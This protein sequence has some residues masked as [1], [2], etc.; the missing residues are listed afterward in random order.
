LRE[1]EVRPDITLGHSSG[2]LNAV[3]EAGGLSLAEGFRLIASRAALMTAVP[4]SGTMAMIVGV[5]ESTVE[6]FAA[7]VRT[8]GA[9]VVVGIVNGP[10]NVVVS[11][12]PDAVNEVCALARTAGAR[13]LGLPV[14]G[15]FH[16]PL[17]AGLHDDWRD[18]VSAAPF[19]PARLPV[20]LNTTGLAT[21]DPDVLR[22]AAVDQLTW[23]V[24]W[25]V[26]H[27]YGPRVRRRTAGGGRAGK[28]TLVAGPRPS[29]G[30]AHP[31]HAGP[32]LP[33]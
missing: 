28:V 14:G 30:S 5:D 22:Q 26:S 4:L 15:A 11:G 17:L 9:V 23:P 10:A 33:A 32:T 6:L 20:V 7:R 3:C 21:T 24:R 2:E 8:S 27:A 18:I 1:R 13:V 16:S 12:A 25:A 29:T 31:V 19:E